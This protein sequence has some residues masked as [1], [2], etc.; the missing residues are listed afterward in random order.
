MRSNHATHVVEGTGLEDRELNFNV[1]VRV[2]GFKSMV[3]R[4]DLVL[5][6]IEVLGVPPYS[7][8]RAASDEVVRFFRDNEDAELM[9]R[10]FDQVGFT[11]NRELE[12][13]DAVPMFNMSDVLTPRQ[14]CEAALRAVLVETED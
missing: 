1:A 9:Q 14:V 2:M 3:G 10:F 13:G 8:D 6:G 4:V 5:R 11:R 7:T 12:P